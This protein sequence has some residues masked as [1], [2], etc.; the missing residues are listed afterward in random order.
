MKDFQFAELTASQVKSLK[1]MGIGDTF[2]TNAEVEYVREVLGLEGIEDVE[3]LRAIRN[4]VVRELADASDE[5]MEAGD[6]KGFWQ[7]RDNMS[8]I[9]AVIDSAMYALL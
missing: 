8:G 1:A 6:R 5:L 4:T 9:T 3:E 2:V 7:M